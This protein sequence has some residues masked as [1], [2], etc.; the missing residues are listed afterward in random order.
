M[1][2]NKIRLRFNSLVIAALTNRVEE[3]KEYPDVYKSAI[4]RYTNNFTEFLD[5]RLRILFGPLQGEEL[6]EA[7]K[8]GDAL[9]DAIE[10]V[11]RGYS[12]S[13][14]EKDV[15]CKACGSNEVTQNAKLLHTGEL[16]LEKE[17]TCTKCGVQFIN[18]TEE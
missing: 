18:K 15:V 1:K 14:N 16:V 3:T 5:E 9:E 13:F 11:Y 7:Q 17:C 2:E 4:K 10:S 12:K 6:T 8:L